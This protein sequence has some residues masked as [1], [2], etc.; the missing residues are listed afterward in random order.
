MQWEMITNER[1][2]ADPTSV[3]YRTEQNE[4]GIVYSH[5]ATRVDAAVRMEAGY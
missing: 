4:D 2:L 1:S 3:H 5:L